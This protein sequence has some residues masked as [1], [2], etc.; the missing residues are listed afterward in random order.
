MDKAEIDLKLAAAQLQRAE[1]DNERLAIELE[2][3]RKPATWFQVW[4]QFVPLVTA[5]VSVA[6]FLWGVNLYRIAQKANREASEK[7]AVQL[8]E[9]SRQENQ[10]RERDLMQPWIKS[11][12]DIYEEALNAAST[13]STASDP[14]L[15]AVAANAFW[16]LYYGRMILVETTDVSA[17]MQEIGDCLTGGVGHCAEERMQELTLTLGSAMASSMAATA[18]M[19]YEEFSKDQFLYG[20]E[21]APDVKDK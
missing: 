11:Q 15:R 5:L 4:L 12:R 14:K 17:A 16:Q 20:R 13:A 9:Q 1:L 21:I 2:K 19:T 8:K 6:G 3:L 7:Q 10:S 18:R